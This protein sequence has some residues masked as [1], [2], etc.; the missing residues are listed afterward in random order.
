MEKLW[1]GRFKKN[2]NK[3]MEQFISSLSFDKKLVKYD[4]LG[5]IAHSQMLG[6]CKIIAKE[7][8]N[9]IVE[10]LKQILK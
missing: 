2:I 1:G 4:L 5:S 6:K 3:E 8:R 7:E 10:G 9:K